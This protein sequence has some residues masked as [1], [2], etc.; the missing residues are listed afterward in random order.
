MHPRSS[1]VTVNVEIGDVNDNAPEKG[2]GWREIVCENVNRKYKNVTIVTVVDKDT[3]QNGPPFHAKILEYTD[4]FMA[5]G[6]EYLI[7]ILV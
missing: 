5:E 7:C 4:I 2:S 1:V 3:P 6:C